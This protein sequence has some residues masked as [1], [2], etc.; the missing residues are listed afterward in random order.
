MRPFAGATMRVL[1]ISQRLAPFDLTGAPLQALALSK[2]LREKGVDVELATTDE[3]ARPA[4]GLRLLPA[5]TAPAARLLAASSLAF[6]PR[7][8][9]FH[10]H[11]LSATA[12][13]AALA[14]RARNT[15]MLIKVS[16]G[17]AEGEL[18][19]IAS[20]R[21]HRL[22]RRLMRTIDFAVLSDQLEAELL[23]FGIPR[24]RLFRVSNGVDLQR[25][26][27]SPAERAE[28]RRELG[29]S[30]DIFVVLYAG[31][32]IARK[33]LRVLDGAWRI[34]RAQSNARLL[35]AGAGP[36]PIPEGACALGPRRDIDR[37]LAAA[38]LL[39]LPSN[40]ES[41][42]N[43]ILEAWA[44]GVPVVATKTGLGRLIDG[45]GVQVDRDDPQSLAQTI[46]SLQKDRATLHRF[47][48]A[49]RKQAERFS[50]AASADRYVEI[51]R[52]LKEAR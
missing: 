34:V 37:L 13:G 31:Q 38:D 43:V 33:G 20:H 50:I 41:F 36:E 15:P 18:Q 52:T 40:N 12:L 5:P 6:A 26:R 9:V 44:S 2:T 49:A 17:G 3:R 39:V 29:L 42:G 51:Y 11:T 46:L 23:D 21:A 7:F 45:T 35:L 25:F 8:D 10:A 24:A 28:V 22:L 19:K 14:A 16:L 4:L 1:M 32:L 48:A 47:G 30:E 27:P